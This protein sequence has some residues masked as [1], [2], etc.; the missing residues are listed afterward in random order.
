MCTTGGNVAVHGSIPDVRLFVA[1]RALL[2]PV[3]IPEAVPLLPVLL[4]HTRRDERPRVGAWRREARRHDLLHEDARIEVATRSAGG[5]E[6][7]GHLRPHTWRR[8]RCR[9]HGREPGD[10]HSV[11]DVFEQTPVSA[12]AEDEGH[13]VAATGRLVQRVRQ[14]Q[15][16]RNA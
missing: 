3:Q 7:A 4:P 15:A 2:C 13:M 9:V 6:I 14:R 12:E 5:K 10:A 11:R 8:W 16:T 1:H